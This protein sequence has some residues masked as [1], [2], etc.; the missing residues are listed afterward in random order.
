M[1][2]SEEKEKSKA[3]KENYING[4]NRIIEQ[5]QR[6]AKTVRDGFTKDIFNDSEK[7][8]EKLKEM[9]GWPLVSYTST[10][11]PCVKTEL[12]SAE[13]NVYRMQF[14]ILPGL[15]MTGLFFKADEKAPLVIVQ[16]GG[17][18]TPEHISGMYGSTDNYNDMLERVRNKGVHAFAPQLLL[19]AEGYEVPFN[20]VET[21]ARLKRVG[22]SITAIEVFGITRIIDYFETQP[23]VENFGM[24]GMSYGG[25]YT[26]YT[27]AI[28]TRIK[29]A[30]SCSFFNNR[31][32]IGWPD[33]VWQNSA[34]MFDDGEVACLVYPRKI[35][36][37][38][39]NNDPLFDYRYTE[40]SF[41]RIEE[42]CPFDVKEWAELKIFEGN[43]EFY[44]G[45]E[46]IEKLV[47]ELKHGE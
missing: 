39:G 6:K 22:S 23:Y 40:E 31:D 19:W 34:E 14:E 33:W 8:R 29:A 47:A 15:E 35:W 25:F 43:H 37:Q 28:D 10:E 41:K 32:V 27:T 16:H 44:K 9:L 18:G 11:V 4:I 46:Y 17:L 5:R 24:V 42:L 30:I 2:F 20:R 45:D 3:Y 7:Y 21:D 38:M 1:N 13:E 36:I 12:L 26:L